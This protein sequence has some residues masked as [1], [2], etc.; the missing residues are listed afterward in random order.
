MKLILTDPPYGMDYSDIK[1]DESVEKA[2]DLLAE[3]LEAV[4]P[5]LMDDAHVVFFV[6]VRQEMRMRE[7]LA[8]A[9][10]LTPR[11]QKNATDE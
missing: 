10:W 5:K 8:Q 1:G 9:D 4:R 11:N 3:M 2:A 7:V 6:G